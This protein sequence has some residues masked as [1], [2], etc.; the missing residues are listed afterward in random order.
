VFHKII[1]AKL[2][3]N[4]AS[5]YRRLKWV[6]RP[7]LRKGSQGDLGVQPNLCHFV[8]KMA[9]SGKATKSNKM[10]K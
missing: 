4:Q 8:P 9:Q 7:T 10:T 2:T 5:L 3:T 6:A 1:V